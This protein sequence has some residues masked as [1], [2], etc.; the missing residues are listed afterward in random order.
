MKKDN[1]LSN[2]IDLELI[3]KC[4]KSY[5]VSTGLG[6]SLSLKDGQI[7][8]DYGNSCTKCKICTIANIPIEKKL[9]FDVYSMSEAEKFGGKYIYSCPMGLTCFVSL[10][11]SANGT[12]AKLTVG[13]FLMFDK[14]DYI[15]YDLEYYD[16][17]VKEEIIAQ[18]ENINYISPEKATMLSELLFM[19]SGFVNNIYEANRMIE[20]QNSSEIQNQLNDYIAELKSNPQITSYPF[21]TEKLLVKAI[22]N[23]DKN[24]ANQYLNQIFGHIFLAGT[25]NLG[26][27]KARIIE[28]FVL[29]SRSAIDSGADADEILILNNIYISELPTIDSVDELCFRV[30]KITNKF[31]D[32]IFHVV[33]TKNASIVRK[34]I[35][36]INSN[37]ADK[38][39]LEETATKMFLSPSYFSRLFKKETGENFNHYLNIVRI[40]ESKKLLVNKNVKIA[41]V[42][43]MVGFEDQSYYTKVF[44]KLTKVSPL[45]YRENK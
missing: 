40:E 41:E 28:L 27:A 44:K 42:A 15:D 13:P 33:N 36:Y 21:Q 8:E 30:T 35:N 38:I 2:N 9:N 3:K 17:K 1:I 34:T 29:I 4:A 31:M 32:S 22:I 16:S 23:S 39:S 43:Q 10:I 19:S 14:Q 12:Y 45:K 37:F 24:L 6:C 18:L 26:M 11:L 20:R 25:V 5:S 7:I